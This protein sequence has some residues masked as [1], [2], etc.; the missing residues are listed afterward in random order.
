M[1]VKCPQCDT[2]NPSDS[3]FCKECATPLPSSNEIPVTVTLETPTEELTRGTLFAN[4]Y[5]IIEELGKGGMGK[6]YR[7]EDKKIKEEVALKL[8]KPEIA[9]DKKT[10]ERFSNELKMARKIAHRNVCKM[11]D[12]G[13][14]KGTHYI[15]MEYVPGEDLKR[16]TR[17]VEQF[18]A[19]KTISIAR[20]VCEGL[21]EAHRLGVV[22][23]DLKPQNIMVDEEGNAR[24]MDFGIARSLKAKGITGAG[25]MVG[26]PEYMSPEQAEVK[27]VDQRSD[28]YSLGVI[29]YEMVTGRVPFEGE[30]PLGIA[31]KHKS[32]MP[33][34]PREFNAQIPEDL[35]RVILTCMEKDKDKRYQSAGEVRS[36]LDRIEAGMPTTER[37]VPKRRPSTSREITVTFNLRK[38]F[39]PAFVVLAIVIAAVV[40]WKLLPPKEALPIPSDKPSVAVMYFK[41][42]TG[43][44]NFDH[45]RSALSDLLIADLS[46]SRYLHVL[47]GDNLY[48]I[49]RQLNLLGARSYSREEM[50][51][52]A[53]RG[54]VNHIIQGDLS[55]A[56]DNFRI[57]MVLQKADTGEILGSES[58]NGK[59]EASIL[60]MVDELTRRI[61]TN[62]MLSAEDIASDIDRE[63]GKIATSSPEALRYYIQGRELHNKGE[64]R[65]SIQMMEKALALDTEFAMAYRSMAM[66]YSNML[67]FSET[68]K[69]LQR[70]FEL[71][72]RLSD[73]ERYL[74]EAEFYRGSELTCDKAIEAY[75]KHLRLYPDDRIANTNLGILYMSTEQ[76]DKA[77]EF[78]KICIQYKDESFFPYVNISEAYRA[79]GMYETARKLL[80]EYIQNFHESDEIRRELSLN[81]FL[82]GE[83][84]LALTELDKA[85]S[86]NPDN[87]TNHFRRGNVYLCADNFEK[88][89]EEYFKVLERKELG[90]HLYA[91]IVLGTLNLLQGKLESGRQHYQQ[92]LNLAETLGD[93]WWRTCFHIWMGYLYL[94]SGRSTDA[95]KECDRAW[96]IAP[97]SDDDLRW[98]RRALYY[99]GRAY[100]A[101]LS[102]EDAQKA[103]DGI[104]EL[105]E[106]G[107]NKKEIRYYHHLLGLIELEKKNYSR[108]IAHFKEA[109]SL[110]PYELGLGPFTNDQ[111][112]FAEP[113]A[114]VY[115]DSGDREK[116]RE[117]YE[118]ILTLTTGKLYYG[119]IYARSLYWLGKIYE[120]EG[121][122]EKAIEYYEKF[123]SLWKDADPGF[124]EVEDARKTLAGLK[125]Q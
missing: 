123:I 101:L 8:I 13:E 94:R 113:L 87:I 36:E 100:L 26:T 61:K 45:W 18:S 41:N 76:W 19:G 77:I 44:E 32:E 54:G 23:R 35:S 27:E 110:L 34:D 4:R 75:T 69:Y 108:A 112:V 66:S 88:A 1:S 74:I 37:I 49:L 30:T 120:E 121:L 116:A 52:V 125:S 91:R 89:E 46:Q 118:K 39:I 51:R 31:M 22:H 7:V 55:K 25:V 70:A 33:K 90:Y 21:A 81:F 115:Y 63:V 122:K 83:Y 28:I 6:V 57:N 14:E 85:F 60:S 2:D 99:K 72:D 71:K 47:S 62:F 10:I 73:R 50:E 117:E 59:G 3:K 16:L 40:I 5:E 20:Q 109:F 86:L 48:N 96:K 64:Y 114:L 119:E 124:P 102:F 68:E 93:N 79:K 98:Q 67:M 92:G 65:K 42:N 29:L 82:Q 17:K 58:V 78:F 53:S 104:K 24:I 43:E 11:Y 97:D 105:V 15:T 38:L 9:S 12:L 111:A 107:A 80:E 84:N 56:G 103:A 95:L 106:K